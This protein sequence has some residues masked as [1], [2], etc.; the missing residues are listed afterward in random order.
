[1]LFPA[2]GP[3]RGPVAQ[4][5]T[6]QSG[7]PENCQKQH[8]LV[9]GGFTHLRRLRPPGNPAAPPAA[10]G[11]WGIGGW[12]NDRDRRC[13][14]GDRAAPAAHNPFAVQKPEFVEQVFEAADPTRSSLLVVGN[15]DE[16]LI[17]PFQNEI[18]S[19]AAS[20]INVFTDTEF[21]R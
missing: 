8:M 1:M 13:Q 9:N 10:S 21:G 4:S 12:C 14:R 19:G 17:S 5:Q 2:A 16:R 6:L 11:D 3:Y 7:C 15:R 20:S 18:M